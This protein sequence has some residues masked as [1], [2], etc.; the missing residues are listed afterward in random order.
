MA[1]WKKWIDTLLEK[2]GKLK[3]KVKRGERCRVKVRDRREDGSEDDLKL[4]TC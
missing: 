4:G 1:V 3:V 2:G